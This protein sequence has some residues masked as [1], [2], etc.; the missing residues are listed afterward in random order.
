MPACGK[1]HRNDGEKEV[2]QAADY[3]LVNRI[4]EIE[5][6]PSA[7]HEEHVAHA[8]IALCRPPTPGTAPSTDE[9]RRRRRLLGSVILVNCTASARKV[10][11]IGKSVKTRIRVRQIRRPMNSTNNPQK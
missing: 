1:K 3:D 10:S 2:T 7:V 9:R 6:V 4:V 8:G 5:L 11:I